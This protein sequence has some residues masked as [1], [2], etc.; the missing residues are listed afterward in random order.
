MM[1]I[2][3]YEDFIFEIGSAT[4]EPLS[5]EKIEDGKY[6]I[7]F[8]DQGHLILKFVFDKD[9]YADIAFLQFFGINLKIYS[10]IL[11]VEEDRKGKIESDTTN[12]GK[13]LSVMSAIV[14]IFNEFIKEKDPDIIIFSG[15]HKDEPDRVK[16]MSARSKIYDAYVNHHIGKLKGFTYKLWNDSHIIFRKNLD[17]E[18]ILAYL[19]KKMDSFWEWVFKK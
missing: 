14:K 13:P 6:R 8:S 2:K 3:K 17:I 7:K 10:A 9:L 19:D 18:K 12:W 1:Y 5:Y 16:D 15:I 11:Y 4:S